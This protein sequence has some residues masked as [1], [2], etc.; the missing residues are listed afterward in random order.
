MHLHEHQ[1]KKVLEE[2]G[3]PTP[4]FRV[5]SDVSEIEKALKEL[6]IT[7]A[8]LKVQVHAGGR[9]KAG[10]VKI[11]RSPQE[12][13]QIG[14]QLLGM[15][16]VNN[17]TGPEGMVSHSLLISPLVDVKKEYYVAAT[18]DRQKKQAVIIASPEGGMEIEEIAKNKPDRIITVPIALDGTI[19]PFHQIRLAK[20]M[21]WD[22][23]SKSPGLKVVSALAKAF[24]KTD[25]SL[26]E[27][28][29]LVET[30]SGEILALDAKM[31]IDDNALFRQE[32]LAGYFDPTQ[33]SS[34]EAAAKDIELAYIRL[35]GNIGCMVNGAGLAMA[36]MDII[37][38]YGGEP[39]NFLDVGGGATKEK[40]T[41]GFKLLLED[42][43]V[44]AIFVNIFG[45]IM[46]CATIAQ[47]ILD[48][49]KEINIPVPL[50]VRMEGTNVEQGRKLL[51]ESDLNILS[52]NSLSEAAQKVVNLVKAVR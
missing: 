5:V 27:I 6:N 2:F 43:N 31:T 10:G 13:V 20:L 12:A 23:S 52:I 37:H 42:S 39:A 18:I 19:K 45:G 35:D 3:V 50:V 4:P 29:P 7:Q 15:T 28:N 32:V 36:T 16:I 21:G 9:G 34:Q 48:A 26:L 8:I 17:Q 25:S 40:I 49:A 22:W 24:L 47:G 33:M 14:K 41:K 1:T 51:S 44:K 38:N 11:A 30:K 46:N